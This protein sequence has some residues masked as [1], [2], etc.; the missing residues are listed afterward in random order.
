MV[1]A[2]PSTHGYVRSEPLSSIQ[3]PVN[4]NSHAFTG[5]PQMGR[6]FRSTCPPLT[7]RRVIQRYYSCS[8]PC[9]PR[10]RVR[11]ARQATKPAIAW[12]RPEFGQA[13][14]VRGRKKKKQQQN[15]A[16]VHCIHSTVHCIDEKSMQWTVQVYGMDRYMYAMDSCFFPCFSVV[17]RLA[18]TRFQVCADS[19]RY[20]SPRASMQRPLALHLSLLAGFQGKLGL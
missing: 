8:C 20:L 11:T 17:V 15:T 2:G 9:G 5:I 18:L 3:A 13:P 14:W 1:N 6:P 7:L 16:A 12:T 19:F 4:A 10:W